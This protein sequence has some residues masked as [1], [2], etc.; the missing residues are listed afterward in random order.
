MWNVSEEAK[1]LTLQKQSHPWY[2]F[3]TALNSHRFVHIH[4]PTNYLVNPS[5]NPVKESANDMI[6][7]ATESLKVILCYGNLISLML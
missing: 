2:F 5:P 7:A 3:Y 6:A 4:A 1:N